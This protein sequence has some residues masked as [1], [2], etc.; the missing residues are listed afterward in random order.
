MPT[1]YQLRPATYNTGSTLLNKTPKQKQKDIMGFIAD[2]ALQIN[3]GSQIFAL[4]W[5]SRKGTNKAE[6]L[7]IQAFHLGRTCAFAYL[8]IV[9]FSEKLDNKI[10][11]MRMVRELGPELFNPPSCL[12]Y[13]NLALHV[14]DYYQRRFKGIGTTLLALCLH[15]AAYNQKPFLRA[16]Q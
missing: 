10:A 15:L 6:A 4:R 5:E 1:I 7:V 16:V 14:A 2:Q 9:P 8:E 11:E 12:E 3:L 13:S